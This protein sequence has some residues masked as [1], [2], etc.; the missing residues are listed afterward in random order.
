MLLVVLVLEAQLLHQVLEVKGV[1]QQVV[2]VIYLWQIQLG[3]SQLELEQKD[4][5]QVEEELDMRQEVLVLGQQVEVV[6]VQVSQMEIIQLYFVEEQEVEVGM[7]QEVADKYVGD[8]DLSKLTPTTF[9]YYL[10]REDERKNPSWKARKHRFCSNIDINKVKELNKDLE[11]AVLAYADTVTDIEKGLNGAAAPADL[12]R[13]PQPRHA[14]PA[15]RRPYV[16]RFQRT[17]HS[18]LPHADR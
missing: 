15:R 13:L 6:V 11:L 1:A 16:P 2:L 12:G 17:A 8:I 9:L 4:S 3:V 10:E 7:I 5:V 18:Q 14:R